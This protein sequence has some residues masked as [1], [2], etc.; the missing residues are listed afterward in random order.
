MVT[1]SGKDFKLDLTGIGMTRSGSAWLNEALSQHPEI[2][3]SETKEIHYFN[4]TYYGEYIPISDNYGRGLEWYKSHFPNREPGKLVGEFSVT[5]LTDP[6]AAKRISDNFPDVKIIVTL[7]Q[8]ADMLQ[9]L[10]W[11]LRKDAKKRHLTDTFE[12]AVRAK[13]D[14]ELRLEQG[15]YYK[16]LKRYYALFP[17]KNIHVV[18]FKDIVLKPRKVC[19]DLY[20]FLNVNEDFEPSV[21]GKRVNRNLRV[22]SELLRKVVGVPLV[23]LRSLGLRKL[24]EFILFGRV[25]DRVYRKVNLAKYEYPKISKSLRSEL[26]SYFKEDIDKLESLIGKDLSFWL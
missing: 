2:Y 22:R 26:T 9:S 25:F 5:Y 18:L 23:F 7:R 15:E 6:F 20:N 10:Y 11:S 14:S 1:V 4:K 24:Y 16:H 19:K 17:R 21:I 8:P 3:M 13:V 12:E